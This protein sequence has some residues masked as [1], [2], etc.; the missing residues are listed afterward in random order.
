MREMLRAV[1]DL[2]T[3]QPSDDGGRSTRG[4]GGIICWNCGLPVHVKA[5]CR[6]RI[7]GSCIWEPPPRQRQLLL[8]L[9]NV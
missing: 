9:K 3:Q 6:A 5:M 7:D 1:R 4:K 2:K 8:E